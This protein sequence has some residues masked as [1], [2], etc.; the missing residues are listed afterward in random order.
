MLHKMQPIHI[1]V[2]VYINNDTYKEPIVYEYPD[3]IIKVYRPILTDEE[4]E[5]RMKKIREAAIKLLISA[6]RNK[7]NESV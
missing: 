5:R 2:V 3:A 7:A 4:H 6:E 1:K